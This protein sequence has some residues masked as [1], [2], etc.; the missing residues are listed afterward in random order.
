MTLRRMFGV[1]HLL[2]ATSALVVA[3]S[4]RVDPVA[5][6]E[7][8]SSDQ[9]GI[10]NAPATIDIGGS[11]ISLNAMAWRDG[12][13]GSDDD[14]LILSTSLVS[15]SGTMPAG[16]ALEAPFVVLGTSV[17]APEYTDE[18]PPTSSDRIER[19]ARQGPDWK[20]GLGIDI[21]VRVDDG[22]GHTV[23]LAKRGTRIENPI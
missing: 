4:D 14:G 22:A 7:L 21:V 16:V 12:M 10:R 2:V 5:L 18:R 9:E 8:P 15:S 3:C 19:V 13:P 20:G 1:I 6:T 11:E 23:F 17:W